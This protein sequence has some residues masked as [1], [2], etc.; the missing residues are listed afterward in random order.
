[1][2]IK[3]QL[4][5]NLGESGVWHVSNLCLTH[6]LVTINK[7]DATQRDFGCFLSAGM[8]EIYH[9]H[10]DFL[11][12]SQLVRGSLTD[13]MEVTNFQV[14]AQ[15]PGFIWG[16]KYN[17]R[18]HDTSPVW[19]WLQ[20]PFTHP[21]LFPPCLWCPSMCQ[22]KRGWHPNTSK[23]SRSTPRL[24]HS[25]ALSSLNKNVWTHKKK[26]TSIFQFRFKLT[27]LIA[28]ICNIAPKGNSRDGFLLSLRIKQCWSAFPFTQLSLQ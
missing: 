19:F 2:Q 27:C 1:M 18:P 23:L 26:Q 13:L 21:L 15:N 24:G 6:V 22:G 3:G 11:K 7:K 8:S 4:F 12:I 16:K 5:Y 28:I 10:Q 17:R 25:R 20:L 14:R 9:H